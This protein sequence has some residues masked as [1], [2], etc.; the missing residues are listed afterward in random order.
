MHSTTTTTAAATIIIINEQNVCAAYNR[1]A[2][3]STGKSKMVVCSW[4]K[5]QNYRIL[6]L[7]TF[8]FLFFFFRS[9]HFIWKRCVSIW[10]VW[11]LFHCFSIVSHAFFAT[12]SPLSLPSI[13]TIIMIADTEMTCCLI[14]LAANRFSFDKNKKQTKTSSSFDDC[15]LSSSFHNTQFTF[16]CVCVCS[17]FIA[18]NIVVSWTLPCLSCS[19]QHVTARRYW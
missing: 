2:Q 3:Q 16:V 17:P 1:Y 9:F 12:F 6:F 8:L 15:Y 5:S 19:S 10:L 4:N 7:L 13:V 11:V 14:H 18:Y